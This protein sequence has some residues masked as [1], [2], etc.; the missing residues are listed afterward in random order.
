VSPEMPFQPVEHAAAHERLADLALEADGIDRLSASALP[1]DRALL[2][3]LEGCSSCQADVAASGHLRDALRVA[4]QAMPDLP[5]IEPI[6]PPPALRAGVL[7][8]ARREGR[9]D[10]RP[11]GRP[12]AASVAAATLIPLEPARRARRLRAVLS[13]WPAAMAAAL[14]LAVIGGAVGLQLG[15]QAGDEDAASM[16]AVVATLD[17]VLTAQ[18]HWVA[19]LQAGSGA[20]VGSVSWSKS[21]FAVLT[22]ALQ[23]PT[24]GGVYRCWL[25]RDGHWD[26]IGKMDFGGGTAYWTGSVG[27]WATV[28]VGAGTQFV[29]TLE[30]N[31]GASPGT[32]PTSP[33]VLQA[34]LAE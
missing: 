23:R 29:V 10:A 30:A 8:A 14:V 20:I 12:D 13:R 22:T 19:P 7:G 6:A 27:D 2:V 4:F 25:Q 3:H 31:A 1:E 18:P 34:D 33:A 5:S 32:G 17:R 24:G 26:A 21:D 15:R 28:D 11:D 16:T 9:P